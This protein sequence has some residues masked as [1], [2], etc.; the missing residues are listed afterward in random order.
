M[1]KTLYKRTSNG[2]EATRKERGTEQ[3]SVMFCTPAAHR[4]L[5]YDYAGRSPD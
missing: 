5:V 1:E 3:D 4:N 2:L